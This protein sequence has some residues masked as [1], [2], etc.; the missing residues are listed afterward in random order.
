MHFCSMYSLNLISACANDQLVAQACVQYF[1]ALNNDKTYSNYMENLFS[2][3]PILIFWQ[4]VNTLG[5]RIFYGVQFI[6]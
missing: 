1:F 2:Y 3:A 4:F 6:T 5:F